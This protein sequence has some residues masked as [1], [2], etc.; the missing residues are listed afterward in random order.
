MTESKVNY[1]ICPTCGKYY[2]SFVAAMG[3]AKG[4]CEGMIDQ[5]ERVLAELAQEE[6]NNLS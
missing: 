6:D 5:K 4:A 1:G 3:H 2:T